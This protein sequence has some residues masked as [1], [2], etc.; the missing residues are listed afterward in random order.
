[1]LDQISDAW[2]GGGGS[3]NAA[4]MAA[5][6]LSQEQL[7]SITSDAEKQLQFEKGRYHH[8]VTRLILIYF[9]V[10]VLVY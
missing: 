6:D 8:A 7:E 10:L 9:K 5:R 3:L 2:N 4:A 1:M